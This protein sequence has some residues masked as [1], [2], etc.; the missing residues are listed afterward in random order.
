MFYFFLGAREPF[1]SP[2]LERFAHAINI[3]QRRYPALTIG[4]LSSLLRVG[5]TPVEKGQNVSVSDIVE[6]SGGQKYPTI[7]R[8]LDL[9]GEGTQKNPGMGLI[10]KGVAPSDKR[11]RWVAIS[12]RGK[13]LLYE[14]DLIL[15]PEIVK[16]IGQRKAS[17]GGLLK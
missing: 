15:S 9:L 5:M 8:Q 13:D 16:T 2:E 6:H 14:L 17:E 12:E 7:A 3:V 10:E 4:Q 11:T 1:D